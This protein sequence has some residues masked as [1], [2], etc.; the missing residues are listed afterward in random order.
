MSAVGKLHDRFGG[1]ITG[2]SLKALAASGQLGYGLPEAALR[3]GLKREPDFIG[4]DMGSVD[5]GPYYLGAGEMA[6]APAMTEHDLREVLH[7][8]RRLDVPLLIGTAGTAGATAAASAGNTHNPCA[9][10]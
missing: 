2:K 10:K 6:T 5:P 1:D 9:M 8:A 7:G 3:E 4:C